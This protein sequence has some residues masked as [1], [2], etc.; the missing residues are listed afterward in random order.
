VGA[1][2]DSIGRFVLEFPSEA[3]PPEILHQ[4]NRCVMNFCAVALHASKDPA[5]NGLIDV[6]AADDCAPRATVI[7][8]GF[9]TSGQNAALANGFLGHFDDFDD[10]HMVNSIHPTSPIFPAPLALSE[11]QPV[12]G[13]DLLAAF[14]IGLEVACRVGTA[15]EANRKPGS[16]NWHP[17]SMFGILG[18]AAATGRLLKLT[19]EQMVFALGIAGTQ[20]SGLRISSGSMCKPLHAGKSAQ[21]GLFAALAAQRGIT[22][23]DRMLEGARGIIGIQTDRFDTAPLV[24]G[25][26][27]H[28]EIRHVGFKPYSCGIVTHGLIDG[29][30]TLRERDGLT[31]ENL[32]RMDGYLHTISPNLAAN[33]HMGIGLQGKFSYYHAMGVALVDGRV[34]PA[35]FTDARV[36]DPMVAAAR[37]RVELGTDTSLA[38]DAAIVKAITKDGRALTANIA[39]QTGSPDNPMSDA[40]TE[41]KFRDLAGDVL[42]AKLDRAVET[43]WGLSGL[44][45]AGGLLPA[46]AA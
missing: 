25:L 19:R 23:S 34:L 4:A 11:L 46:L 33:R 16:E 30:L 21:N 13:R 9:R 14:A 31:L 37:D 15:V 38:R 5:I 1:I 35:Q 28:W 17:T 43:L 40:Q 42:G 20:A 45:N 41:T 32:E 12:S 22:A 6:F 36:N 10:T 24:E 7:G 18:A 8:K 27:E 3:I 2:E 44:S 39:H 29:V 26:G